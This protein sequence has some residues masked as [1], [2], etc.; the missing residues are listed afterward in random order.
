MEKGK[1]LYREVSKKLKVKPQH[2]ANF[3][4]E[5][6]GDKNWCAIRDTKC[7]MIHGIETRWHTIPPEKLYLCPVLEELNSDSNG[8][9]LVSSKE[10]Q[11]VKCNRS[12]SDSRSKHCDH[13][14]E[15]IKRDK[16]RLRKQKERGKCHA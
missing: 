9:L 10:K 13:C 6:N 3:L 8:N 12:F 16:A 1:V 15:T 2:C 7:P 11:C 14:R 5:F 4:K